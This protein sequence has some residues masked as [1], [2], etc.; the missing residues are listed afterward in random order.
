MSYKSREE[1][2]N[3]PWEDDE[4]ELYYGI[5]LDSDNKVKTFVCK[6][7]QH[8][9]KDALIAEY[10]ITTIAEANCRAS[11]IGQDLSKFTS[12]IE[13]IKHSRRIR[14]Y[15]YGV[16]K[17]PN[18]K[19]STF[20]C[21]A[22]SKVPAN[23]MTVKCGNMLA[24]MAGDLAEELREAFL[25]NATGFC[26]G[27]VVIYADREGQH[28]AIVLRKGDRRSSLLFV[29]SNPLWNERAREVTENENILLGYPL[30]GRVSYFA[31]V[32]RENRYVVETG[33]SFPL[34][35]V[36]DLI[37]EFKVNGRK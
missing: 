30:R 34:H 22:Q 4:I 29:T 2:L 26:M 17:T 3:S 28:T 18:G 25:C 24:E 9:P 32:V 27:D 11:I 36:R 37:V 14:T 23:A 31:P 35:R 5:Y 8:I 16:V 7:K 21:K 19:I 10:D 12:K 1:W 6:N 15:Y 20:I 33:K 13:K